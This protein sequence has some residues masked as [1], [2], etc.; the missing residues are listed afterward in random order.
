MLTFPLP[1]RI[2]GDALRSELRAAG[3]TTADV[4]V[5]GDQVVVSGTTDQT[6]AA[7]VVSAHTGTPLPLSAADQ[8]AKDAAT[9]LAAL[10]AKA[11][12]VAAGTATFT[13]TELQTILA[14]TVL[15]AGR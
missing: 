9:A 7:Q 5:A 8:A 14:A 4:Y 2:D 3:L 1:A 6:K 11:A 13:A 15:R 10:R 12:T